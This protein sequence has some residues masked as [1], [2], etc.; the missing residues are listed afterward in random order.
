MSKIT[1]ISALLIAT[2]LFTL[3]AFAAPEVQLRN[4]PAENNSSGLYL[5]YNPANL[6]VKF[7]PETDGMIIDNVIESIEGTIAHHYHQIGWHLIRYDLEINPD[8]L[9]GAMAANDTPAIQRLLDIAVRTAETKA[10]MLR[11]LPQVETVE[12]D[13]F[14]QLFETDYTPDDPFFID[15]DPVAGIT[16][17]QQWTSFDVQLPEAWDL[18]QGSEDVILAIIDTGVDTDHP[19]LADNIARWPNGDVRGYDYV[20]GKNGT[21]LEIIL[22]VQEDDNPDIHHNDGVDDGWGLPDP[23]AGDGADIL[24]LASDECD[25]GVFHGTHCASCAS[26]VTDNAEGVA[27]AGFSVKIM[28]VRCANPEG[29][30]SEYI[31]GTVSVLTMGINWAVDNGADIIS[32]SLGLPLEV[33]GLHDAC[34][35]AYNEGVAVFAASG[36]SGANEIYYP[37]AYDE[38]F[39]VG[40]FSQ[41]HNRAEFSTYAAGDRR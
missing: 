2:V 14:F 26:A 10:E 27:G 12:Y 18:T 19:D 32:M 38:T 13:Y 41:A 3:P 16:D 6:M 30:L 5:P 37:A 24:G 21:I 17:H 9:R 15:M 28:P 29:G 40:S 20:G 36:N 39:A 22:P 23:S 35:Y 11:N 7:R 8:E 1:K 34:I 31:F 25:L 4:L 33:Q